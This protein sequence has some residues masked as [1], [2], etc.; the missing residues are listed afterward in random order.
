MYI[1]SIM[2]KKWKFDEV[3]DLLQCQLAS[4]PG[5]SIDIIIIVQHVN[6]YGDTMLMIMFS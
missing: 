1:D 5:N 4:L 2:N 6:I 3:A